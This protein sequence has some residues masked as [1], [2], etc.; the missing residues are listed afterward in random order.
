MR[1]E[2]SRNSDATTESRSPCGI[3]SPFMQSTN[4]LFFGDSKAISPIN[5]RRSCAPT[6]MTTTSASVMQESSVERETEAGSSI[7]SFLRSLIHLCID[8]EFSLP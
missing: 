8:A 7:R 3:S 4:I 2:G 1:F 6:E 5:A